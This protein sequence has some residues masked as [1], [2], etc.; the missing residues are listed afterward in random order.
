MENMLFKG[1]GL[2]LYLSHFIPKADLQ[3]AVWL[4]PHRLLHWL[5]ALLF[6]HRETSWTSQQTLWS[7]A[8]IIQFAEVP[9]SQWAAHC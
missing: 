4:L 2:L 3:F 7:G 1:P 8:A 5:T 9:C 6:P